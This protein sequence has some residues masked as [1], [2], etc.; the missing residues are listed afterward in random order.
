[1]LFEISQS[2]IFSPPDG[3]LRR[4]Q[5]ETDVIKLPLP[6]SR[7]L[8][9]LLMHHGEICEREYLLTEV[10]D[11]QGL[12][13]SNGNLNHYIS[14]LRRHFSELG[15]DDVIETIPRVGFKVT[16]DISVVERETVARPVLKNPE[17]SSASYNKDAV[18]V[19]SIIA[20]SLFIFILALLFR[21]PSIHP[22]HLLKANSGNCDITYLSSFSRNETEMINA[23]VLKKLKERKIICDQDKMIYFDHYASVSMRDFG[24]SLIAVCQKGQEKEVVRCDNIYYFN[25]KADGTE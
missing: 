20:P 19:L 1:M 10:W 8:E 2:V 13:G 7:L 24:R 18:L 5:G 3:T 12:T 21:T 14:V 22:V 11:R 6:A 23:V 15:L 4:S 25:L 16:R 17:P 9:E